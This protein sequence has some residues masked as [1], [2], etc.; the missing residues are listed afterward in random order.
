MI[1]DSVFFYRFYWH[2]ASFFQVFM[3]CYL[4]FQVF[5]TSFPV[6]QVF[7]TAFPVFQ[8]FVTSF[9]VSGL[10]DIFPCF[11]GLCDI[12]PCFSGLCD[13][14]PY[15][16]GVCDIFP[17]PVVGSVGCRGCILE[18]RWC[19]QVSAHLLTGLRLSDVSLCV[20]QIN[21]QVKLWGKCLLLKQVLC[22]LVG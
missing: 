17:Q 13:I 4:V 7:V 18:S 8:V 11:S 5:V 6:F 1:S 19:L 20:K 2:L 14:F 15:F 12:F 22:G 9:P 16:S 3:T 10:C 21:V